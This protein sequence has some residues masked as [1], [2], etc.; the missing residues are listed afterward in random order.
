MKK[1]IFSFVLLSS[2]SAWSQSNAVKLTLPPV[3]LGL[4]NNIGIGYE[5]KLTDALAIGVKVNFSTKKAAPLSGV[6]TDFAKEQ[7]DDASVNTDI[8]NNKFKSSGLSFELK[9]FPGKKAL[10]GF[11]L[12]PYFGI[13]KGTLAEFSFDFPDKDN[14]GLTHGG[15][16]NIGFN[17]VGGG[18]GIGNQ[19]IIADRL[20][21]DVLWVGLGVG[22]NKFII[23]GTEQA[24]EEV[25]FE[26]IDKDVTDFI[27]A[28]EGY[29]KK[30]VEK[31]ESE[32][33][34]D[35]IKLTSKNLIPYSKLLNIS[36]GFTF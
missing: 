29:V 12:A 26:N 35:Y 25:D 31:I 4:A 33:T 11:Y 2:L 21:I 30:Y 17:F 14:P 27:N 16:V 23:E 24:G 5:R 13:Q 9:Y 36:I 19:W 28:Q 10:K 32:Y 20:S 1:L 8:F 7:L 18:I 22:S 15:D 34:D 6:L 3:K